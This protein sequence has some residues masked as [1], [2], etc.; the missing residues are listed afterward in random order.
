MRYARAM[1]NPYGYNINPHSEKAKNI[2]TWL[3]L[4]ERDRRY[5][6]MLMRLP[7]YDREDG[8]V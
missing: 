2:I 7:P 4:I 8:H 1:S 3:R 5:A 6:R